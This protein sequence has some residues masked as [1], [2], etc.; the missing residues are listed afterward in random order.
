MCVVFFAANSSYADPRPKLLGDKPA[1]VVDVDTH[2]SLQGPLAPRTARDWLLLFSAHFGW[3]TTGASVVSESRDMLWLNVDFS[4]TEDLN[5]V[6]LRVFRGRK[7]LLALTR[8]GVCCCGS[9]IANIVF[10]RV[11]EGTLVDVTDKVWPRFPFVTSS[12]QV[13]D[14]YEFILK[15][16]GSVIHIKGPGA[17]RKLS[18]LYKL[19]Y[20]KAQNRFRVVWKHRS[21][22]PPFE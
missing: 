2:N 20:N 14:R 16:K 10:F 12:G 13:S 4:E 22:D 6:A 8:S 17:T 9:C 11:K 7:P 1:P 3:K 19:R 18:T 21:A 15:A 5:A